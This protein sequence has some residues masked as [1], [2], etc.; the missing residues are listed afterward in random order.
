LIPKVIH[1]TWKTHDVP[2]ACDPLVATWKH[3]HPQ[4]RH[5]LWSDA[6]LDDFVAAHYPSF[7]AIF[8]GYA[9]G[10][11]RADAARYLFLH[12]FGGV[13]ADIDTECLGP[14]DFLCHEDRVIFCEEPRRHWQ[15]VVDSRGLSRLVFN[16]TMASPPGH[17]FWLHLLDNL[18]RCH[19]TPSVLDSTGPYLLSGSIDSY[20]EPDG[21]S[22][23]S[24]HVFCGR[25]VQGG[26][27][28][29]AVSGDYGNKAVSVHHWHGSWYEKERYPLLDK[30]ESHVR[31]WFYLAKKG[32]QYKPR[33]AKALVD[34]PL[35]PVVGD[36]HVAI[37]IP[38]RDA[39]AY[40]D[41][42][43][44]LLCT[45]DWPRQQLHVVFC[46]GDSKDDSASRL[47][48]LASE[49]AAGFGSFRVLHKAVG[50]RF[51]HEKRWLAKLQRSRR[52]GLAHV[53][54]HLIDEG[55]PLEAKWALWI[56]V[57][58][59]AYEPDVLRQLLAAREKIVVPHCLRDDGT[60]K[61]YDLNS[62]STVY[63]WRDSFYLKHV[64]GGLYQPPQN[65]NGV[66]GT[67]LLVQADLHRAGLRFPDLP[68]KDLIETEA[69]GQLARDHGITAVGLPNVIIMHPH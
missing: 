28:P 17:P 66:G 11:Q 38:V 53:R 69:F 37:L 56:D 52:S 19:H 2:P 54:N 6:E 4:W 31:A 24:A 59:S 58:V 67:M 18:I 47:A 16:G 63:Q 15:H 33:I 49:N 8:R 46:E 60:A 36:E 9:T 29:D 41:R 50:T 39:A 40:L 20:G 68:Y 61:T 55:L 43:L 48:R 30:I 5:V 65:C 64:I 10:V 51:P 21:L 26:P 34:K 3:H 23:S 7:L 14:A 57:D 45:L 32:R 44:A 12:H 13:Y 25:E 22:I 27:L 62:F 42:C 1:Q 35:V